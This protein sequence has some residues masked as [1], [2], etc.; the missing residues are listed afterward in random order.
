MTELPKPKNTWEWLLLFTPLATWM[1]FSVIIGGAA[2]PK[3]I[4]AL[5]IYGMLAILTFPHSLLLGFRLT[6]REESIARRWG[7]G[8]AYGIAIEATVVS[9]GFAGC[10]LMNGF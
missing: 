5:T 10:S 9:V 2:I 3:R 1:F 4:P 6:R 7:L 8:L